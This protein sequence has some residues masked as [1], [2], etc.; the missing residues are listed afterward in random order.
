MSA[1]DRQHRGC[2]KENALAGRQVRF[3]ADLCNGCYVNN[4]G[5]AAKNQQDP[6]FGI[7]NQW[8]RPTILTLISGQRPGLERTALTF[9]PL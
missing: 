5:T 4:S 8:Q 1:Y 7:L 2:R 6:N 3:L 9:G